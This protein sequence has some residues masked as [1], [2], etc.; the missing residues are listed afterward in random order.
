[1]KRIF[2]GF[3]SVALICCSLCTPAAAE[4]VSL[5][6]IRADYDLVWSDE[7]EGDA[8]DTDNWG[9]EGSTMHRNNEVQVYCDNAAQNNVRVEGGNLVIEARKEDRKDYYG[10]LYHYTS[11]SIRSV[12]MRG[13]QY[14][15]LEARI[16]IPKGKG[17]FPAF[18]MCGMDED[19]SSN[20]PDD[21]EIDIMEYISQEPDTIHSTVHFTNEKGS[22][23]STSISKYKK[24]GTADFAGEFHVFSMLWTE[25]SMTMYVD[26]V[27]TGTLSLEDENYEAFRN[28]SFYFI[29]NLAL[30]GWADDPDETSV[31]PMQM[32]VDY[33][34]VYQNH[35]GRY[36]A[37]DALQK[38]RGLRIDHSN[39][40]AFGFA[41]TAGSV[42]YWRDKLHIGGTFGLDF[43][44]DGLSVS[45][46]EVGTGMKLKLWRGSTEKTFDII[47]YGDVDG[48]GKLTAMDLMMTK[49][50]LL[51]K[52]KLEG[53][54]LAAADSDRNNECTAA[55][56]L[57]LKQAVL[58]LTEIKQQ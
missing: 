19:N 10:T 5:S 42:A 51:Q 50:H 8:L 34:R 37:A 36:F 6:D 41:P 1:M 43:L 7:F 16:Q 13:F 45:S 12:G 56:L 17:A 27:M 32:L 39:E 23:G 46:G 3:L 52:T 54:P 15:L 47:V 22:H 4:G 21:G 30:G 48:N 28:R 53:L 49:H 31:F 57:A 40:T 2:V 33:V 38:Y 35:E 25:E 29:L 11:G 18:W 20:W 44:K 55:D 9:Y 24:D 14:G 26:D 58:G